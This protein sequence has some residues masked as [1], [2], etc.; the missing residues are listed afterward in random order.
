MKFKITHKDYNGFVI[1]T[2]DNLESIKEV[3]KEGY[4][5]VEIKNGK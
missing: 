3:V 1:M 4:D 5:I 2:A